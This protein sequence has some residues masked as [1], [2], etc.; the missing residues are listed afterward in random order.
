MPTVHVSIP[1]KMYQ[2]LKEA[3][4]AFD[5]QITD[6]VKILIRNY[7]PLVKQGILSIPDMSY[8]EGYKEIRSFIET[9]EKR[10]NEI[11]TLSKSFI[12]ASSLMLQK[13]EEKIDKLEEEVYDLKVSARIS[14]YIEPEIANK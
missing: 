7:L 9:L 1:D 4:D 13:L 11:D 6:L 10:I 14:K 5:I 2:E 8:V 12:R 3:A